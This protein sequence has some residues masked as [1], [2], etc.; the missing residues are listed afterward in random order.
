MGV[1]VC[2]YALHSSSSMY[3]YP[4]CRE[5]RLSSL[6]AAI[7]LG[8]SVIAG[9]ALV[10]GATCTPLCSYMHSN[11]IIFQHA[12]QHVPTYMHSIMHSNMFLH[13]LYH[14]LQHVPTC[15]LSCTPTCSYMHSNM[16]LHTLQHAL[17]CVGYINLCSTCLCLKFF[18]LPVL[19]FSLPVFAVSS[20][21]CP[22]WTYSLCWCH[23]TQW[24]PGT[25]ICMCV[26]KYNMYL[27]S[28]CI[29]IHMYVS[30]CIVCVYYVYTMYM[31]LCRDV[32]S[33]LIC[34][35]GTYMH[36]Q[37]YTVYLFLVR[38]TAS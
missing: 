20:T 38:P 21:S 29:I 6:G 13:A 27:Y 26:F 7:L 4:W 12:L 3:Y 30:I 24:Y 9:R 34:M 5:Q 14:A 19:Y 37:M 8:A 33:H 18:P 31:Y 23:F 36:V 22:I 35:Y 11:N 15:T 28:I 16:F 2:V 32:E 1:W 25:Y 10:V 17:K